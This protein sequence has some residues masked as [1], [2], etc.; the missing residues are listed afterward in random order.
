MFEKSDGSGLLTWRSA[1]WPIEEP[2]EVIRLRD[3]RRA[4]LDYEGPITPDRGLVYQAAAG[5]YVSTETN[6]GIEVTLIPSGTRARLTQVN[7][8][9][10]RFVPLR[11]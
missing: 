4:Y 9:H 11:A 2:L 6:D 1:N 8:E 7:G 10:W 5:T 3:H